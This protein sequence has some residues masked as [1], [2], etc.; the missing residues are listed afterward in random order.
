MSTYASSDRLAEQLGAVEGKHLREI[1]NLKKRLEDVEAGKLHRKIADLTERNQ[2][3]LDRVIAAED[4]REGLRTSLEITEAERDQA[5][6][7]VETLRPEP[8][9]S[10]IVPTAGAPL[11]TLTHKGDSLQY[12]SRVIVYPDGRR[13]PINVP[14]GEDPKVNP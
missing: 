1:A 14:V 13:E 5:R 2:L 3:M 4:E 9:P 12:E 6:E 8:P 7:V 10:A 11:G